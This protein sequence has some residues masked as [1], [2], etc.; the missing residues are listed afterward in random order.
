MPKLSRFR[1]NLFA[2][3]KFCSLLTNQAAAYCPRLRSLFPAA[4]LNG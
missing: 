1:L 4:W 2:S 3:C